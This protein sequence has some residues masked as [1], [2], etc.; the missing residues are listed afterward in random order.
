MPDGAA[1]FTGLLRVLKLHAGH[2][3]DSEIAGRAG[4]SHTTV[5]NVT[6][7][8]HL[9]PWETAVKIIEA[10]GG[11]SGDFREAWEIASSGA[12]VT[13][14]GRVMGALREL[15]LRTRLDSQRTTALLHS[16]TLEMLIAGLIPGLP[17]LAEYAT[18][19]DHGRVSVW[20]DVPG[21]EAGAV[22]KHGGELVAWAAAHH[23]EVHGDGS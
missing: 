18:G 8:A 21:C 7:G 16:L 11:D 6:R 23:R 2:P 12:P 5:S 20:H 4:L 14:S 17:P 9:P 1:E 13:P 10:L 15:D 22:I 19:L 3:S